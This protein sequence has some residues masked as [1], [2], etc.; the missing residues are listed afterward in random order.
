LE[1]RGPERSAAGRGVE[2]PDLQRSRDPDQKKLIT[3]PERNILH[4]MRTAMPRLGSVMPLA[5]MR[6][7]KT[8]S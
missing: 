5:L 2:G 7:C 8:L 1:G 3:Q 4:A 6:P